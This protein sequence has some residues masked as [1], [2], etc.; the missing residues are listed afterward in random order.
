MF[1]KQSLWAICLDIWHPSALLLSSSY[2]VCS[3]LMLLKKLE[4]VLHLNAAIFWHVSAVKSVSDSVK[5][6]LGSD[7]VGSQVSCDLRI[8]R[9]AELTEAGNCIAL[10]NLKSDDRST[11]HVLNDREVLRND[12]LVHIVELLND[13]SGQIEKLHR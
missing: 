11:S 12:A 6:E 9:T 10:T 3:E 4:E 13:W 1:L 8:V 5:A 7:S 2:V